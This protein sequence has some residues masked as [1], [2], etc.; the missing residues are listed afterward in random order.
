MNALDRGTAQVFERKLKKTKMRKSSEIDNLKWGSH[1]VD[2]YVKNL[3]MIWKKL[4]FLVEEKAEK[5]AK[6][7]ERESEQVEGSTSTR[8]LCRCAR[9]SSSLGLV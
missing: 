8:G 9:L 6:M 2:V 5:T 7:V 3:T 1:N 4:G